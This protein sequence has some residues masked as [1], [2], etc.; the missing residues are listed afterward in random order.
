M[1][2]FEIP[3]TVFRLVPSTIAS[4]LSGLNNP[5]NVTMEVLEM[6]TIFGTKQCYYHTND[7]E[8]P[9]SCAGYTKKK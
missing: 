8:E 3:F 7:S 2:I 6:C 5:H 9:A 1:V 4:P